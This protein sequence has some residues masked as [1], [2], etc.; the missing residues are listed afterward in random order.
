MRAIAASGSIRGAAESLA[1]SPSA[2]NRHIQS[3]E[4]DLEIQIF[5]RVTTGVKLTA[6]GEIFLG[7]ALGQ[8]NG[9]ERVR[10][11]I[12]KMKGARIGVLKVGVSMDFDHAA[13]HEMIARFQRNNTNIDVQI[14]VLYSQDELYEAIQ[15]ELVEIAL[16]VNPVMRKGLTILHGK[17][18][19]LSAFVPLGLGLGREGYLRLHELQGIRLAL[20]PAATQVTQRIE[21]AM[22][23][24]Q[25]DAVIHYRGGSIA[26]Y[27]EHAFS[28]V[29]GVFACLDVDRSVLEI[30]GYKRMSLLRREI[31]TVNFCVVA[32]DN[33]GM[34][35]AARQFQDVFS[36]VFEG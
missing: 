13:L 36:E 33:R 4:A 26:R 30:S 27:L 11:Q 31:G 10:Q 3:L 1:I 17:D 21:S 20:P 6:E 8:L 16:F 15:S 18:L 2:L 28:A 19:E 12:S 23:K 14:E 22:E 34:G 32:S 29:I 35:F 5:E 25:L 7:Y 9:F 24:N